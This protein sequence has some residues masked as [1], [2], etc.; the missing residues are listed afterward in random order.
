MLWEGFDSRCI[1]LDT[2]QKLV[3]G[4]R[5]A[6]LPRWFCDAHAGTLC[7]QLKI[8]M[9]LQTSLKQGAVG[10]SARFALAVVTITATALTQKVAAEE[11]RMNPTVVTATRSETKLDETL[12]DVRVITQEQIGNFAGRSLAEIMQRLAGVR[13]SSNGGRGNTQSFTIRGSDQVILLIDGV[14][15]GSATMGT[16]TLAS[17]PI[18]QIE[19]IEVVQGPASALYGSDAIGGVI[20][21]FTKQGKG[22]KKAFKPHADITWGSAGY[23]DANAGFIG[24]QQGWNYSLNVSRVL[25]PGFSSTNKK[26]GP[27]HSPDKDKFNQTA[28]SAS[29]GY[30]FNDAWRLDANLLQAQSYA[31]FDN[32]DYNN[33]LQDAWLNSQAGT[34]SL[35]L[36]GVVS[37]TWKTHLSLARSMDKQSNQYHTI[38]TN[39]RHSDKFNT[40]QDE[41]QWGNEIKTAAGI[42]VAGFDHLKQ[43]ID[44]STPYDT[45]SRTTNAVYAGVNGSHAGHSWQINL[46]RDDNSQY[47]GYNTWGLTYGYEIFSSLKAHISRSSSLTAPTFNDLYYPRSGNPLLQPETAKSNEIGLAWDIGVHNLKL[48]GFDNK[49]KNLIAWAPSD[50]ADP[51]S[52]WFPANVNQAQLKGWSLLYSVSGTHWNLNANYERLNAHD[53]SGL[54]LYNLAKDQAS[55]ALDAYWGA[56]KIGASALHVGKRQRSTAA[57][58]P[59]YTTV[60]AYAEYQL[61]KDW[62]LQARVANLTDKEYETVYGYNQRGRAGYLTLKWAP[63]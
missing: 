30:A 58:L 45:T 10:T 49:V 8:F 33:L 52:P 51:N 26:A 3:R 7:V 41:I 11:A 43:K 46:R 63:K 23:K 9:S 31:E 59:S 25:D 50:P 39:T 2:G 18:E 40:T 15:F 44:T 32:A 47:G 6:Q 42:V 27:K 13:M 48:V 38:S 17:L 36:S 5:P 56:W 37:P 28:V 1:S 14:R 21:I 4:S 53:G 12:A 24:T 60:D 57:Y 35:K 16:P 62:A 22:A 29:L 61:A 34:R 20:Q 19:R 55:V 54:P